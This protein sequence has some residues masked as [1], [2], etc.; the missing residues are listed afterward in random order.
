MR[1][2]FQWVWISVTWLLVIGDHLCRYSEPVTLHGP[3]CR[4][5]TKQTSAT[6]AC[7][8]TITKKGRPRFV[9]QWERTLIRYVIFSYQIL[10]C[11]HT[12]CKSC[13]EQYM[14]QDNVITCLACGQTTP[15]ERWESHITCNCKERFS[16][17]HIFLNRIINWTFDLYLQR[18]EEGWVP[19]SYVPLLFVF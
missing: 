8:P 6:P 7:F 15:A 4:Q 11:Y 12:Y 10:R 9:L 1:I 5:G 17:K 14:Y 19:T 16:Y 13:L 18:L 2:V 3:S